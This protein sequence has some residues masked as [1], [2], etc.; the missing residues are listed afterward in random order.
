MS[1]INRAD[2][3]TYLNLTSTSDN[4]QLATIELLHR[5]VE[6]AVKRYLGYDPTEVTDLVE[7]YPIIGRPDNRMPTGSFG[8]VGVGTAVVSGPE[9]IELATLP[10]RSITEVRVDRFGNFGQY[11]GGF[12]TDTIQTAGEDYMLDID[13]QGVY[14]MSGHLRRRPGY[15]WPVEA[16][17]VKVTY[18]AG[19]TEDELRGDATNRVDASSIMLAVQTSV[20]FFFNK[21]AQLAS[22]IVGALESERLGDYNYKVN[23]DSVKIDKS[24]RASGLTA[25][26]A[27]LLRPYRKTLFT[28]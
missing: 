28:L 12:G 16:G 24:L 21:S 8:Q 14:S 5:Q 23:S 6:S 13:L 1:I 18:S 11:S 2:I 27:E 3:L 7:Y 22:G 25:E 15:R 10:V 4:Q 20:A 19:F 9:V 17:S 26:A